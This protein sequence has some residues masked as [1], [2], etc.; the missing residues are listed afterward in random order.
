LWRNPFEAEAE[1]LLI[2]QTPGA[3]LEPVK[4]HFVEYPSVTHISQPED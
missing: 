4:R 1:F 3:K 2:L